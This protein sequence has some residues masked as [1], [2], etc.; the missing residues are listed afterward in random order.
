[1]EVNF[2]F[3]KCKECNPAYTFPIKG[4]KISSTFKFINAEVIA[5]YASPEPTVS[6][7]LLIKVGAKNC[8][9]LFFTYTT[10]SA[11]KVTEYGNFN[12]FFLGI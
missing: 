11:P 5:K 8:F 6:T 4:T 7:G 9:L 2:L 1:M 3:A 10:P 12:L